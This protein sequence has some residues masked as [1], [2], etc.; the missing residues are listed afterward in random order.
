MY[1]CQTCPITIN[2]VLMRIRHGL[3]ICT[4]CRSLYRK[5]KS[6]KLERISLGQK[7]ECTEKE[8]L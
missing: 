3:Y 5:P 7:I 6:S 4:H 8:E 1:F 2:T